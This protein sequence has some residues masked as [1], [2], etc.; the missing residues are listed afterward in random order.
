MSLP[1]VHA[2]VRAFLWRGDGGPPTTTKTVVIDRGR[3]KG[4]DG[5]C[6][7]G[8]DARGDGMSESPIRLGDE[9]Q[10]RREADKFAR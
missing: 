9:A 4:V 3:E 10:S 7:R 6:C 8:E 1:C 5:S 2:C